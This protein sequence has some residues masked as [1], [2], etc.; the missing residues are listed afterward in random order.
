MPK[1]KAWE[2]PCRDV[3]D[4]AAV[5][6][7]PH[8]AAFFDVQDNPPPPEAAQE[9]EAVKRELEEELKAADPV[10]IR[11]P[12]K[13]V[14]G[15]QA[16]VTSEPGAAASVGAENV[17]D[18]TV[19]TT[20]QLVTFADRFG[21]TALHVAAAYGH[22]RV[23]LLLLD[24]G[25]DVN[26][27][28]ASGLTPLHVAASHGHT[29][30]VQLFLDRGALVSIFSKRYE[31]PLQGVIRGRFS[32]IEVILR[33]LTETV[34]TSTS[35]LEAA[36]AGDVLYLLLHRET[37]PDKGEALFSLKD[38][39][40]GDN[41]L[42][43]VGKVGEFKESHADFVRAVLDLKLLPVDSLNL[44]RQTPLVC[45]ARAN[46]EELIKILLQ[47]GANSL[48]S[49]DVEDPTRTALSYCSDNFLKVTLDAVERKQEF[50]QTYAT[51]NEIPFAD[52]PEY[53][54]NVKALKKRADEAKQTM[55]VFCADNN[56]QPWKL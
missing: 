30:L 46:N 5:G 40:T 43:I 33:P 32:D 48:I 9:A 20:E 35:A 16:A 37:D 23:C 25:A 29:R 55:E 4:L 39:Q 47:Y 49:T 22:Y 54:E 17:L 13:S 56:L 19:A 28:T 53:V 1:K 15:H 50:D 21:N 7:V 34:S 8:F 51:R 24:H 12:V 27:V 42:H 44:K 41:M 18:A 2:I 14:A 36:A 3:L 52:R 45:A 38:E 11:S 31:L 6:D 26:S 10:S